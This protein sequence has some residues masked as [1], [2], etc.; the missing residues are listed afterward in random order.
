MPQRIVSPYAMTRRSFLATTAATALASRMSWAED[1]PLRVGVILTCFTYRSHAHVIL[2]NFLEDYLF[3]GRRTS[4]GCQVV[5]IYADQFPEG[6]MARSVAK[7]Y[8]IPIYPTIGEALTMGGDKLAVDAVLAIG[9][10]GDYPHNE[11]D[12]HLYPRKEFFDDIVATFKRTGRVAPVFNDKHLSYRW[13]WAKEMYDTSKEMGFGL[14]AG[15]SVPLAQRWPPLELAP[16]APITKAVSIHGGGVESYDFHAL[17]VLQSLFEARKGGETGVAT[18]Q[19]L[20]GDAL[21]NAAK[22]GKWSIELADAA[23]TTELGPGQPT[24]PELVKKA[25]FDAPPHGIL[26]GYRDGTSAIALKV[27]GSGIRWSFAC[28][29]EGEKKPRATGF[30]VGP[31]QNRNLFRA[32]SH[33]I[34]THFREGT[35][36]YPVERTLLTTGIVAAS[37][38]SRFEGGKVLETDWLDI[39]YQPKDFRRCREMGASWKLI[40]EGTPQPEGIHRYFA[41]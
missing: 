40:P 10:H 22:E 23:M 30:Y 3:N 15:S 36:P 4:P 27:G 9:E 17:E 16:D 35:A 34:Q 37:M 20:E 41:S 39:T 6:E 2:E 38:D 5:S 21:W 26:I 11:K 18:V 28:E 33:A 8:G 7:E 13:D 12:Q 24:L 31:W 19:F 32:L 25:P 14:M 1:K 29:I